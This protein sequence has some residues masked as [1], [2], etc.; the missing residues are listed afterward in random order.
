MKKIIILSFVLLGMTSCLPQK[1]QQAEREASAAKIDSLQQALQQSQNESN[2]LMGTI[3]QIQE[4]FRQIN[5]AEG[6][7][8]LQTQSGEVSDQI[9]IVDNMAFIQKTLRLNRELISSLKQQ[10]RTSTQSNSKMKT[11]LEDMVANFEQQLKQKEEQIEALKVELEQRD[12][13][14]AEQAQ[15]ISDLNTNVNELSQLNKDRARQVEEQDKAL[16]TAYYVFGTKKELKQ[17]KIL[18]GSDVLTSPSANRDYFTKIDIR[19]TKVIKLYSKNAKVRTNHPASSYS[20]DKDAQGLYTLR[21]SDP[22]LFWSTSKYLVVVV[23]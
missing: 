4:G 7:V 6:R 17:Q 11:T 20:L 18:D 2:D 1:K 14:I 3:E 12:V 15:Q 13:Q 21:I 19:V 23:K 8:T 5:E 9:Q 10:L 16:H 22:D